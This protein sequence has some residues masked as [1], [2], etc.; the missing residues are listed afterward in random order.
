M[1]QGEIQYDVEEEEL[2]LTETLGV[3][4]SLSANQHAFIRLTD[5]RASAY[6]Y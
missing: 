1:I 5:S 2:E 3:M 6:S 4:R